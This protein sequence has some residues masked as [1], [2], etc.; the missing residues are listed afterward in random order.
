[1]RGKV[2]GGRLGRVGEDALVREPLG[3]LV[4][5]DA[6]HDSVQQGVLGVGAIACEKDRV[7]AVFHDNSKLA[8]SVSRDRHERDVACLC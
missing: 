7:I 3:G 1:M 8:G 5:A 4:G 2:D 6:I